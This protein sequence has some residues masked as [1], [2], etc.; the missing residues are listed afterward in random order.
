[1]GSFTRVKIVYGAIMEFLNIEKDR[2][3]FGMFMD[4]ASIQE[5]N[6]TKNSILV[7]GSESHGI[8]PSVADM[9]NQKITIPHFHTSTLTAE[10]LN[11]SIAS[12]ILLY[13]FSKKMAQN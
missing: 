3:S 8:S 5:Q 6:F 4:G 11:A 10:S 12:G 2:I 7:I 1:M 13:E 9:I